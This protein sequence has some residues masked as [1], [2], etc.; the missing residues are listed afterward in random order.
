MITFDLVYPEK[1]DIKYKIS[2]FPDGQ[3]TIDLQDDWSS[4]REYT[5][6]VMI[7]SRLNSFRDLELIICATQA[8]RNVKSDKEIQLYVPYFLG[9][10]SDRKFVEGGVN[11]LKQV[12]CPIIN[13]QNYSKVIT[14]DPHSD[15]LEACLNNYRKIS[16]V[17]LAKEAI[18]DI[19]NKDGAQDRTMIVSPDA[20]ALKK[21]Y[22]I[23]KTF[24]IKNVVTA[25]KI[26]DIVTG[27]IVKTELPQ[28]N[29]DGIEQIVIF[30]DICDGGRTFIE[31]A[32][33]IKEQTDKPIYLVVTH[34]IFSAGLLE[35]SKH[36]N[37]VYSTNSV[38]DINVEEYSDFT[39]DKYFLKQLNI[40]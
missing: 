5:D 36:F 1:S 32:K 16:N 26:R 30:D 37:G 6:P 7:K 4:I 27:N 13:R 9:S 39:V 10:R 19:D 24:G 35:L 3:Q 14:L 15:V 28:M 21:I 23:A 12:I 20:G 31:L 2:Q 18:S 33:V 29:L 8:V 40:F 34:G 38:K 22:D 17:Q 11:Y 25:G